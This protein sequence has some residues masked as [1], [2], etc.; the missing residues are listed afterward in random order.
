MKETNQLARQ[1]VVARQQQPTKIQRGEI[2]G[3]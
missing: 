2:N 3:S 1:Q